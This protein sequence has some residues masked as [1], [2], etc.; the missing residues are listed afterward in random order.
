MVAF[1]IAKDAMP[2][3]GVWGAPVFNRKMMVWWRREH[4]LAGQQEGLLWSKT[5]PS[6]HYGEAGGARAL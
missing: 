4:W 1:M 6:A 3:A 2:V 5:L